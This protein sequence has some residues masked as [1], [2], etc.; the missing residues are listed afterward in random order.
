MRLSKSAAAGLLA[1]SLCALAQ[2]AKV[3][4]GL[5][6]SPFGVLSLLFPEWSRSN[7]FVRISDGVFDVREHSR[8]DTVPS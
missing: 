6:H 3:N 8:R 5:S 2:N 4:W 7:T 1:G